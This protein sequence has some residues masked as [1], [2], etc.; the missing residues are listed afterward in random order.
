MNDFQLNWLIHELSKNKGS[1]TEVSKDDIRRFAG[2]HGIGT[3][4]RTSKANIIGTIVK[5]GL[6]EELYNAFQE[7]LHIPHWEVAKYFGLTSQELEGLREAGV[8]EYQPIQKKIKGRN[9][10]YYAAAFPLE[11]LDL[12]PDSLKER[13]KQ[14]FTDNVFR[15][16]IETKN[17]DQLPGIV[18]LLSESFEMTK[19]SIYEHNNESGQYTYFTLKPLIKSTEYNNKLA[20]E[21]NRLKLSTSRLE[22]KVHT[23]QEAKRILEEELD[24]YYTK[25]GELI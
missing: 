3:L 11:V 1:E 6:I 13:H 19:I 15:V 24:Q 21:L 10:I 9:G 14:I 12:D 23:L 5:N 20:A 2:E 16:R 22:E 17:E 18:A 4:A 7:F 8:I 25:Y